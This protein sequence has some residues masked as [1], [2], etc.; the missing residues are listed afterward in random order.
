VHALH[1]IGDKLSVIRKA[2]R[3]LKD[4]GF[5]LANLELKNLKFAGKE[6]SR[7]TFSDFLKKQGFTINTR[8]HHLVLKG[9]RNFELPVQY[10]GADDKAGPNYTG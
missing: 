10:I 8:K 5:F 7:K 9:N 2:A 3:W 1:Y 4:D 6:N